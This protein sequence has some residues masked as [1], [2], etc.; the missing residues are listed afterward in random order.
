M[1][2]PDDSRLDW[3]SKWLD[4][5]LGQL[6]VLTDRPKPPE[7]GEHWAILR[8]LGFS[9]DRYSKPLSEVRQIIEKDKIY[10]TVLLHGKPVTGAFQNVAD[11]FGLSYSKVRKIYYDMKKLVDSLPP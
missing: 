6:N 3:V 4:N 10:V 2:M 5:A 1:G 9:T 8:A 7:N 11:K